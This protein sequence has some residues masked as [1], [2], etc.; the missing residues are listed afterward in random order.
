MSSIDLQLQYNNSLNDNLGEAIEFAL[1]FEWQWLEF[2]LRETEFLRKILD[3]V[4]KFVSY[5]C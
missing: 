5:S 1:M 4:E 3:I 2:N